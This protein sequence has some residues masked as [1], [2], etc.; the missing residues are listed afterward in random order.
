MVDELEFTN[1]GEED[2]DIE[3]LKNR[4]ISLESDLDKLSRDFITLPFKRV[5]NA[6]MSPNFAASSKGWIIKENGDVEFNDGT[7]RGAL[8]ASTIDIGGSDATSFHVDIDGN[9]WLGAAIF[10]S[11]PFRVTNAGALTASNATITGSITAT[12]GTIGGW[13]I[14][15]T[16][17]TG[18][19]VTLDSTGIITGGTIRTASSTQRVELTG[20]NNQL[21]FYDSSGN[22]RARLDGT[23]L[24]LLNSIGTQST[25]INTD[26]EGLTISGGG[27]VVFIGAAGSQQVTADTLYAVSD[28]AFDG[29]LVAFNTTIITSGRVLQGLTS[30]G[31]TLSPT[32]T[33]TYALGSTSLK[34]SNV[35]TTLIGSSGNEVTTARINK[36][37][38]NGANNNTIDLGS[39]AANILVNKHI[40][41]SSDNANTS[42]SSGRRWSDVRTVLLN[43]AD[44]G[45]ANGWKFREYP[46]SKE[47]IAQTE[48]WMKENANEGIQILDDNENIIAVFTRDG[49]YCDNVRK[50]S[51]L[52]K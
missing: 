19:S 7:F 32:T 17:L 10:A 41:P 27:G 11:A 3:T 20:S 15:S 22:P 34:W 36:I 24:I 52:P 14:G 33:N 38:G 28:V 47:D 46:C 9:M 8:S 51:E 1:V 35:F 48:E 29:T 12:T 25:I 2:T 6:F 26:A 31:Q 42:G 23:G 5:T 30:L 16:T 13:T 49:L 44:I 4:V 43:G 45:L 37:V 21:N 18:G 39:E 50:L 40:V